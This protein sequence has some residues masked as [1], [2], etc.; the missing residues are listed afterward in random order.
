[1]KCKDV[2]RRDV[3]PDICR[4]M[5]NN[6]NSMTI[7]TID[8]CSY[9]F[10]N[11][12]SGIHNTHNSYKYCDKRKSIFNLTVFYLIIPIFTTLYTLY[13]LN[14]QYHIHN[15]L[16]LSLEINCLMSVNDGQM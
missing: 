6:M 8:E 1:M 5:I 16:G 2:K 3:Q 10:P 4:V 15:K 12:W 9:K 11:F 7:S 14:L 13:P